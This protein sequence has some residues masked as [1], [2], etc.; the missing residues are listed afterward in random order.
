M[1]K[2]DSRVIAARTENEEERPM[3]Q[4][5]AIYTPKSMLRV[6]EIGFEQRSKGRPGGRYRQKTSTIRAIR[7][8]HPE[9]GDE[10]QL[11]IQISEFKGEAL[12]EYS[13]GTSV[14]LTPSQARELAFA[15]CPEVREAL[16]IVASAETDLDVRRGKHRALAILNTTAEC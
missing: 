15:L 10:A 13:M 9:R 2:T 12:R 3:S 5:Q 4:E 16:R 7:V 6:G 14:T 8:K 1:Q 11:E